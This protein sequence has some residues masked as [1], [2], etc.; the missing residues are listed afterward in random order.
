MRGK[1]II[2]API[3]R[4]F[5]VMIL[6]L[7]M[8]SLFM[9]GYQYSKMANQL[10]QNDLEFAQ[11]MVSQIAKQIEENSIQLQKTLLNISFN[12]VVQEFVMEV[13]IAARF[14]EERLVNNF[15]G[16]ITELQSGILD[17]AI[18]GEN[19]YSL[20]GLSDEKLALINEIPEERG[21]YFSSMKPYM[22]KQDSKIQ[23]CFLVSFPF[24]STNS[25]NRL[26]YDNKYA[27]IVLFVDVSTFL[28]N[29]PNEI[30]NSKMGYY[31]LDSEKKIV[32][33]NRKSTSDELLEAFRDDG[34]I[35]P[36]F[37]IDNSNTVKTIYQTIPSA[38]LELFCTIPNSYSFLKAVLSYRSYLIWVAMYIGIFILFTGLISRSIIRPLKRLSALF[39]RVGGSD[40]GAHK[41]RVIIDG[42]EEITHLSTNVNLMFEQIDRLTHDIIETSARLYEAQFAQ[43]EAE[44]EYLK[45]Q[46]NPHFLYNTLETI[47][48]MAIEDAS[49][50][51]AEV[52]EALGQM[53]R[54]CVKGGNFIP[55][56]EELNIV[57]SYLTIQQSRFYNKFETS[58]KLQPAVM[59]CEIPKMILQP[60][61]ENAFVHGLEMRKSGAVITVSVVCL[62]DDIVIS[63][64]DNGEG[65]DEVILEDIKKSLNGVS[66]S[67]FSSNSDK[68]GII[69]VHRRI[70]YTFGEGYGLEIKSTFGHGAVVSIKLPRRWAN[71]VQADFSG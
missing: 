49:H 64:E 27:M 67:S 53:F 69:N 51:I 36:S 26:Q 16:N 39:R 6:L 37:G 13:D 35:Q 18:I 56:H 29:A 63:V 20:Q 3:N 30:E 55:I 19:K 14:E 9:L 8:L 33:A 5:V 4:Q 62:S 66:Q 68:I 38:G 32:H 58:F 15:L 60:L 52:T 2:G 48:G 41:K 45:S 23:N 59:N 42:C 43:K 65:F 11:A 57:K 7:S 50:R 28:G 46:I 10:E 21:F 40:I 61:V 34:E 31:I 17:I 71:G 22:A 44:Y 24:V 70:Q 12:K 1:L 25:N 47:K 54:Y